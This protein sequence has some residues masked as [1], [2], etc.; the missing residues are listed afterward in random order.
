MKHEPGMAYDTKRLNKIFAILSV[1]F[2]VVVLWV[3]LDDYIRPWKAIQVKGLEIKKEFLQKQITEED[4]KID[5]KQLNELNQELKLAEDELKNHK[6]DLDTLN[7][8]LQDIAKKIYFQNMQNGTF[9]SKASESQ[10]HFEHLQTNHEFREAAEEKKQMDHFKDLFVKGRDDLKTFEAEQS[11]INEKIKNIESKKT[12]VE[13]KIKDLVGTKERL[14]GAMHQ[15][16]GGLLWLIRNS[17]FIDYMDP[18]IKIQQ[19][20]LKN[21]TDDRYFQK[22]AKVDRCTTCHVFIDQPGY[23][24]QA[25]PYKTHPQLDLAVG[26][27]SKH[28]M[29]VFGCT[30]CHGGEGHR[31]NDFNSVVHTPQNEKQAHE[32]HEKYG[33][34]PPHKSPSP[35]L[36]LQYTESACIKCHTGVDR[37]PMAAKLNKGRELIENYG[38][39]GCHKISGFEHLKKP[40]PSLEKIAAKTSKEFIKNW[41]WTPHAFNAKSRMPSFFNQANNSSPEFMRLNIAEVNAMSEYLY[42]KS[43]A[44]QP[45]AVFRQGD[46]EKGKQLIQ[47]VGCIACHQVEG[48]DEPYNN[49]RSLK[50][51]N[52]TGIGS[53]ANPDWLVSWLLKPSHYQEDTIMPSF[54]LSET[55]ANDIA[56]YLLSLKNKTF[57]QLKFE[58][59]NMKDVKKLLVE[60]FSAFDPVATAEKQVAKMSSEEQV[61]E[62]GRRS[63]NK[64]G[65]YSCH[66]I[67]GFAPDLPPIGPELSAVG[68]KFVEQFGWG[69]QKQLEHTRHNWIWH[70]LQEPARWDIGVAKVFKDLNRMPNFYLADDDIT[71]IT[72]YLL[73][74]VNEEIPLT[75]QKRLSANEKIAEDGK[76]ITYK[77]N[78]Q[79]CHVIDGMGGTIA[80]AYKDDLAAAPPWLVQEGHRVQSEWLYRFLKGVYPI[81]PY[82]NLRMPSFNFSNEDVNKIVN[83]FQFDAHQDTFVDHSVSIQWEPGEKEAA[84][85]IFTELACTSCHTIGFNKENPQ[86]P[87]LHNAKMRLRASWIEKWLTNPPAIL[88]YTPMPNFWDGGNVSAVPGVLGDDPKKQIQAVTKYV[89][90]MGI[91]SYPKPL[92]VK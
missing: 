35:M 89:M 37:I 76:K 54:R 77:Y 32:W 63:I 7:D 8:K 25:N 5:S 40:G 86:G 70:H 48:I 9:G 21:I 23:E 29:K 20:V 88:P 90:E 82:L 61:M 42:S 11:K 83:Y 51:P 67:D 10:F 14:V 3:V 13:K 27:D 84:Q 30:T 79:G 47:T 1:L 31:V 59:L 62:L 74:L 49:V 73:G 24:N 46:A 78:C 26:R 15:T 53:K 55:E 52:L 2:L 12:E 65:C 87:D 56:T 64:Y 91:D 57:E 4:K 50:A 18:T 17:P 43:K 58:S 38:C 68:S 6:S 72:N 22:T 44:Y 92:T 66:K 36:P 75:G 80:Q 81:R 34:H 28:P 60:Y 16:E 39:Y 19:I 41:I 71:S 85:K 69:Q 33:W 45:F